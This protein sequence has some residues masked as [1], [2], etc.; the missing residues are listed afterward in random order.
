VN[1]LH[2]LYYL[3]CADFLE[4]T[5]RFGFLLTLGVILLGGCLLVPP[6]G[7]S[8]MVGLHP[9]EV[10]TL[11]YYR[12]VYNSAWVGS[13]VSAMTAGLLSL[14][15]FYLVK[16]AIERDRVTGVGQLIAA[17]PLSKPLY[18]LGKWLSNVAVLAAM[19]G[20]MALAA[21]AMQLIRGEETHLQLGELLAPFL[22]LTLPP[23]VL[24]AALVILFETLPGLRGG[25]GNAAYALAWLGLLPISFGVHTGLDLI[26]SS[27]L[28]A[29]RTQYPGGEFTASQGI[30]PAW[31]GTAH[32][33]YWEGI[34]WTAEIILG[35]L[36]WIGAA[37][38]VIAL[39][40]VAF[41]YSSAIAGD[42]VRPCP[43][44]KR[45]LGWARPTLMQEGVVPLARQ[46][47]LAPLPAE[48]KHFRFGPVL[49]AE[50]RL[51]LGGQPWWWYVG[52]LG[53]A[54]GGLLAPLEVS[55][56]YLLPAAWLWPLLIWSAMGARE[57]HHRTE[58]LVFSNPHPLRR[59]F[60]A[61]W[62]SGW[63]VALLT[64]SGVALR[65]VLAGGWPAL[66]AW[67]VGSL[68]IPT[69]AL[70]LGAWTGSGK[71]FEGFYAAIWYI[72]PANQLAA[73]DFMGATDKSVVAGVPFFYLALTAILMGLAVVGRKRQ[74]GR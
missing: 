63:I 62:L 53:W 2:T 16:G 39:A 46:V 24:V 18:I 32:T 44:Q 29:L 14:L 40:T 7:A 57:V 11:T 4:R 72:G 31:Y 13:I 66:L 6:A 68:F 28:T 19:V 38:L 33:F 36:A 64:G 55:R 41:T 17:S 73:L 47:S 8:Y 59:Q 34:P 10:N 69:L 70:V 65:L 56:E 52:A 27:V 58:E 74:V 50:L 21:G 51:A 37:F 45:A 3:V 49:R 30:N 42:G 67:S 48:A 25:L 35:R 12:G 15:G 60:P 54:I 26:S 43:P 1:R 9:V 61:A 22:W 20:T 5:R 71:T 23:L